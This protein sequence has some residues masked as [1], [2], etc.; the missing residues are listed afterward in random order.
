MD[1][2]RM[3]V[4]ITVGTVIKTVCVLAVVW[5]LF[6]LRDVVLIVLTAVVIASAV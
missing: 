5:L 3:N 1:D 4:S 6:V 2:R